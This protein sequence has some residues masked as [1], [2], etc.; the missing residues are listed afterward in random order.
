M[1]GISSEKPIGS[2]CG[3]DAAAAFA[4]ADFVRRSSVN[5]ISMRIHR[6]QAN[7]SPMVSYALVVLMVDLDLPRHIFSANA[8]ALPI[9]PPFF[10]GDKD[11]HGTPDAWWLEL[12]LDPEAAESMPLSGGVARGAESSEDISDD[13]DALRRG[14]VL[15]DPVNERVELANR[16]RLA[17]YCRGDLG[18]VC[19]PASVSRVDSREDG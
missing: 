16:R 4:V 12:A 5:F 15:L 3:I 17:K 13:V 19:E 6:K 2:R 9:L 7:G 11:G 8:A 14:W 1:P 18:D 10:F